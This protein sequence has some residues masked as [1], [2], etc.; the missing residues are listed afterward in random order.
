MD[1]ADSIPCLFR[2]DRGRLRAVQLIDRMIDRA[3]CAP[4]RGLIAGSALRSTTKGVNRRAATYL[5]DKAS[6]A[7]GAKLPRASGD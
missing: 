5:V 7:A 6:P 1:L 2:F 3:R 4:A